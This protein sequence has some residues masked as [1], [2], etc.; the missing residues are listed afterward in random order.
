M[1]ITLISLNTSIKK[2]TYVVDAPDRPIGIALFV[3]TLSIPAVTIAISVEHCIGNVNRPSV[4][5][6]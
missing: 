5:C 4:Y 6:N 2:S 3:A 1:Q